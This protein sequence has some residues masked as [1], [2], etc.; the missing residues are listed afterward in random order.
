[1]L[2]IPTNHRGSSSTWRQIAL[3]SSLTPF[4]TAKM[5]LVGIVCFFV[6]LFKFDSVLKLLKVFYFNKVYTS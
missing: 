3:L 5:L 1:M 4:L 6:C 2:I